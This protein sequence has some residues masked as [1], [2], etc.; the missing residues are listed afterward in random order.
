MAILNLS[1]FPLVFIDSFAWATPGT[2]TSHG[3]ENID[4]PGKGAFLSEY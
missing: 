3:K 2:E 4:I 1:A